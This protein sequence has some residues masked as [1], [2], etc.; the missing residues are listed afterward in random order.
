MNCAA[1]ELVGDHSVMYPYFTKLTDAQMRSQV[2]NAQQQIIS[3]T[4]A[5]PWP[6]FR[7]R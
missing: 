5:D 4:G 1:G 7:P 6:R 2:P 3:A